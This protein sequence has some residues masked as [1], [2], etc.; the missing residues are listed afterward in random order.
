ME[1]AA[2]LVFAVCSG[3]SGPDQRGVRGAADERTVGIQRRGIWTGSGNIFP[4]VLPISS[5]QQF[6]DAASR[7]AAMDRYAD[8]FMGSDFI[9]DVPDSFGVVI[10]YAAVSVGGGGGGVFSR[11]DLLLAELVSGG[12]ASGSGGAVHDGRAGVG[13]R[14][15]TDFR[16]IA[17]LGD[18]GRIGGVAVDVSDGR[19]SGNRVGNGR[20]D[21]V[22]ER[23]GRCGVA[24][25]SGEGLVAKEARGADARLEERR[26]RQRGPAVVSVRT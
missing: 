23:A 1:A 12:N 21:A 3:V 17:G 24:Q 2:I 9:G 26:R 18:A 11:G 7:R 10:L 22:A 5:A 15:R 6:D 16:G 20:V 13:N 14:G 25:R 19:D 4:R 8:D